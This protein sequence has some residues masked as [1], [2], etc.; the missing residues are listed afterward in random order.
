MKSKYQI[1]LEEV[2]LTEENIAKAAYAIWEQEGKPDG[3]EVSN[4]GWKIKDYHWLQAKWQ[5]EMAAEMDANFIWH[6]QLANPY[7]V[8]CDTEN[9]PTIPELNFSVLPIT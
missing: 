5:L 2:Y 7:S 4:W 3:E 9:N 8:K 1:Q 6:C